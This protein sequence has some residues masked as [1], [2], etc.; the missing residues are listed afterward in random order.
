MSQEYYLV[1]HECKK[2]VHVGCVGFS[3]L[4]WWGMVPS[5]REATYKM[6]DNCFIHLEKLAFVWEQGPEDET[7]EEIE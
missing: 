6:L 5:V 1:C 4:Q 7:Y 2:K 3:G